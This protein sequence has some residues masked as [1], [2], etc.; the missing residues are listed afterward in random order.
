[1]LHESE[2]RFMLT[3]VDFKIA[4]EDASRNV[5]LDAAEACARKRLPLQMVGVADQAGIAVGTVYR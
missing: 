2:W 3:N 5:I 4:K 1:M